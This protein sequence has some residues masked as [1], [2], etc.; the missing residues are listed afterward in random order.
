ERKRKE[1]EAEA[2]S[3]RRLS[4]ASGRLLAQSALGEIHEGEEGSM[5]G[6]PRSRGRR[7]ARANGNLTVQPPDL[8]R[9]SET[10]SPTPDSEN[11]PKIQ[12]NKSREELSR[13]RSRPPP[14]PK[15]Y[16]APV[17]RRP[18]GPSRGNSGSMLRYSTV[19]PDL[20]SPTYVPPPQ[21]TKRRTFYQQPLKN[22]FAWVKHWFKEGAKRAKS[23]SG[24]GATKQDKASPQLEA[25]GKPI[26]DT[27]PRENLQ[28]TSTGPLP[29]HRK[30]SVGTRPELQARAT[31]PAR[32]RINTNSS[33]GSVP[34][35]VRAKR[36][37]LS[38]GTLTPH[39]SYRRSSG[40][41][42]RK[43][44]S[45]SVSSIRST[46]KGGHQHTHSKASSTSSASIASP[47]GLSSASGSR[48]GRSPHSSVKILP[49]TPTGA[50]AL[51]AGIRVSRRPPP[52]TLGSLPGFSEARG[53]FGSMGPGSPS[54]PVFA[55]KKRTVF[56]GP[57]LGNGSPSGIGRTPLGARD[58]GSGSG[59][60]QGRRSGDMI[61]TGITEEDEE[62]AEATATVAVMEEESAEDL[63]VEEV[64][65]FGPE[66]DSVVHRP[67][68]GVNSEAAAAA[69]EASVGDRLRTP[70]SPLPDGE[71]DPLGSP[72]TPATHTQK[73]VG[74]VPLTAEALK[75]MEEQAEAK[76]KGERAAS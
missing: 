53:A 4:A 2:K 24:N 32:P 13:S 19:N 10:K 3:I 31:M 51:P 43:S 41:R 34:S 39:S 60:V 72:G 23:P 59:S 50:G 56:K 21:R 11:P 17:I 7:M 8:P 49:A 14:P 57:M 70:L 76:E 20:L 26:L 12:K 71:N 29:Q 58:T 44:T 28:R 69:D 48:L 74:G 5:S 16:S 6:S 65:Q 36:T 61:T 38:P 66:L 18:R 30:S 47:S 73:G 68:R 54:L 37:S 75:Q 35:S 40:L 52:G 55:R 22:Q 63:D 67:P 45:S 46:F 25:N 33:T 42:G 15:D 9:V 27:D 1:R 62:A 64:D